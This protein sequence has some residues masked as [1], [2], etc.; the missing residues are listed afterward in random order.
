[1]AKLGIWVAGVG[2]VAACSGHSVLETSGDESTG[3]DHQVAGSRGDEAGGEGGGDS[4]AGGQAGLG[5]ARDVA[6][7]GEAAVVRE[8]A[9]Q[10]LSE[11]DVEL[12]PQA[13]EGLSFELTASL[14][15]EEWPEP[16]GEGGVGNVYGMP[17][18]HVRAAEDG[19]LEAV[20][21]TAS[22]GE[23]LVE[24]TPM[25]RSGLGWDLPPIKTCARTVFTGEYDDESYETFRYTARRAH[26]VFL[27]PA[28][29]SDARVRVA[30][31]GDPRPVASDGVPDTTP[32]RHRWINIPG[33]APIDGYDIDSGRQYA[34]S[35]PISPSS[36]VFIRDSDG[37]E[38]DVVYS[39][40][41]GF[42]IGYTNGGLP[43]GARLVGQVQDLA[44]NPLLFEE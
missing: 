27:Q 14:C 15:P 11:E 36:R 2:I 8:V 41:E 44:G 34:F 43:T 17:T 29:G 23:P 13:I 12:D 3:G 10:G 16:Q 28:A 26:L 20:T 4:G 32:P 38:T 30:A 39:L 7:G 5:G 25:R 42:L 22:D 37:V 35:E 31:S 24:V 9:E 1:M 21:F 33:H 40:S 6:L 19:E 18:L